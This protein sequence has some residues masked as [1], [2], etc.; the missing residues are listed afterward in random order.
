MRREGC[1]EK[2]HI[3]TNKHSINR[4][5][6]Y[7]HKYTPDPERFTRNT[8]NAGRQIHRHIIQSVHTLLRKRNLSPKWKWNEWVWEGSEWSVFDVTS[9]LIEVDVLHITPFYISKMKSACVCASASA[10]AYVYKCG[11][12][13]ILFGSQQIY[14]IVRMAWIGFSCSVRISVPISHPFYGWTTTMYTYAGGIELTETTFWLVLYMTVWFTV[15]QYITRTHINVYLC[16]WMYKFMHVFTT[17]TNLK[18]DLI[19][20]FRYY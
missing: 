6:I 5:H 8:M 4:T 15:I 1:T 17:Q 18:P 3:L 14:T 7:T 16:T 19:K 13:Y 12:I 9:I 10:S 11:C 20:L 2:I